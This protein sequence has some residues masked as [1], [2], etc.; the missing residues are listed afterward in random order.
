MSNKIHIALM[1]TLAIT[2]W[3]GVAWTLFSDAGNRYAQAQRMNINNCWPACE[4]IPEGWEV[5][6]TLVK[7]A[8]AQKGGSDE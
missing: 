4:P 2:V 3:G 1:V 5:S 7:S 8:P 6:T